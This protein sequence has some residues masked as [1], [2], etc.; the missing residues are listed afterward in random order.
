MG[1][2][3]WEMGAALALALDLDL[4]LASVIT[5]QAYGTNMEL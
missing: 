4:T 5:G 3:R 2:R 1:D